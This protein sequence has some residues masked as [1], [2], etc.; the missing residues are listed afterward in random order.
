MVHPTSAL[1]FLVQKE[2]VKK[3]NKDPQPK[4][5]EEVVSDCSKRRIYKPEDFSVS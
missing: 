2:M 5:I 3:D 4:K 1:S